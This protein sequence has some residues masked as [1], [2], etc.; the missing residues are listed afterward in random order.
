MPLNDKLNQLEKLSFGTARLITGHNQLSRAKKAGVT[1][2]QLRSIF[3]DLKGMN[4][5]T[6]NGFID[7]GD[8]LVNGDINIPSTAFC[9]PDETSTNKG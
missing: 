7:I 8:Q 1:A 2:S 6:I 5:D 4:D 3:D 9:T